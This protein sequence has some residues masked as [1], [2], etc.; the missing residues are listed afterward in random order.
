MDNVKSNTEASPTLQAL[1][2][3]LCNVVN[4]SELLGAKIEN[5]MNILKSRNMN[6]SGIYS[7]W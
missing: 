1:Q 4:E 6:N 7:F 3:D 5:E 2:R